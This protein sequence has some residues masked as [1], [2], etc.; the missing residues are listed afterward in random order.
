MHAG[1][2]SLQSRY[3]YTAPD[4]TPESIP[5][6]ELD[7][8]HCDGILPVPSLDPLRQPELSVDPALTAFAQLGTLKLDCDRS[9]I[10]IIDH[11]KQYIL[12][13][14]TRSISLEEK[15]DHKDGDAIYL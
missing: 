8:E 11:D 12:A 3:Y 6:P 10:S 4:D 9:F 5:T 15:D 2:T 14:S 13:E 7:A 1:L